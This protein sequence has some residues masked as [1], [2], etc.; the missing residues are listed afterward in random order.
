MDSET[1]KFIEPDIYIEKWR[2]IGSQNH[3]HTEPESETES[4]AYY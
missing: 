2:T 3:A 4:S 1:S